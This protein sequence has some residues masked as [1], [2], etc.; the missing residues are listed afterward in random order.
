M[1]T[2]RIKS[3]LSPL[4]ESRDD[5]EACLNDL[6]NAVNNLRQAQAIRDARV[7][8]INEHYAPAF[9]LLDQSIREYTTALQLWAEANPSDFPKGRKSLVMTSGTIG[10]RTGTPKLSLLSRAWKWD[11]VLEALRR[12]ARRFIRTKEEIDKDSIIKEH[13]VSAITAADL[14][15]W[16]LKVTQQESFFVEP[17]LSQFQTRQT[18]EAA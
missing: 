18:T 9:A 1:K 14:S 16:G 10:F 3:A 12:S 8:E 17:D 13:S 2:K 11:S 4:L 7:L 6:A 15:T 5:A